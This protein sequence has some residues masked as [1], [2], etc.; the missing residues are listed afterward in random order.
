FPFANDHFDL[1]FLTSVFTHMLPDDLAHY[2]QEIA[3]VLKPN[4][5]SLI[6]YFLL[7]AESGAL[8]RA[9]QGCH[10]FPFERGHCAVKVDDRPEEAIAYDEGFIRG[11][12]PERGLRVV[13]P[14]HY[15]N[16]CGRSHFVDGQDII[17]ATKV[18]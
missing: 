13:E 9:G 11:L 18:G 12:Y 5:T 14:I 3:R 2:L 17:I 8:I 7:N 10:T 16:W 6:T 4:G 1:V 15:G